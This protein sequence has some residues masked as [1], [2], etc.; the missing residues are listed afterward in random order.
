MQIHLRDFIVRTGVCTKTGVV[1]A[2]AVA[3]CAS[4]P[5]RRDPQVTAA[6]DERAHC[7]PGL[8]EDPRIFA[9]DRVTGGAPVVRSYRFGKSE[10]EVLAG[11]EI[12][13]AAQPGLTSAWITRNLLCHQAHRLLAE[14]APASDDAYWL[15]GHVLEFGVEARGD[16]FLVS[17]YA[18]DPEAARA[19]L[20]RAQA[21]VARHGGAGAAPGS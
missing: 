14:A 7:G 2:A 5:V 21:F 9:P 15:P 13:I 11:S 12:A 16:V 1:L 20:A 8:A 17:I 3:A 19:V 18:D 10:R 4:A 6:A